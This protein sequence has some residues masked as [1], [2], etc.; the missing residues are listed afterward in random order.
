MDPHPPYTMMP[1]APSDSRLGLLHGL[2]PLAGD[3]AGA[4]GRQSAL[5]QQQLL[6]ASARAIELESEPPRYHLFDGVLPRRH[7]VFVTE[8]AT[9]F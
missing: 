7:Y 9:V 8:D 6:L 2:P 4:G 1:I 5:R 3:P